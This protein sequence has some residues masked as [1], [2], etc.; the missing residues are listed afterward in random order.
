[1]FDHDGPEG[2]GPVPWRLLRLSVFTLCVVLLVRLVLEWP[3]SCAGLLLVGAVWMLGR[4]RARSRVLA[5]R[6]EAWLQRY[7]AESLTDAN[8][9]WAVTVWS[10]RSR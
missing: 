8:L 7:I 4:R 3:A 10:R 1:M 9:R 5:A 6:R 2:V